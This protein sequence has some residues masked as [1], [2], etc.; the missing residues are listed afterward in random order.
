MLSGSK[1]A[2]SSPANFEGF[3]FVFSSSKEKG[4]GKGKENELAWAG[5]V[6]DGGAFRF[7]RISNSYSQ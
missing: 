2:H 1:S 4:G 7:L 5:L 6:W 3:V